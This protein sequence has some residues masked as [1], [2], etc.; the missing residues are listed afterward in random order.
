MDDNDVII[1][2]CVNSTN[3]SANIGAEVWVDDICIDNIEHVTQPINFSFKM[4]NDEGNHELRV[5]MKHK[6]FAHSKFDADGNTVS[7]VSLEVTDIAIDEIS[8]DHIMIE[9]STYT[10]NF[11]GGG[12]Q[13]TERFFGTMGCN[14]TVSLKFT[15]PVYLFLLDFI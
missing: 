15:T 8:L 10:H 14:G 11:N 4:S 12:E 3:Y 2:G 9:T 13:V 6:D 5:I 7:T 1:S